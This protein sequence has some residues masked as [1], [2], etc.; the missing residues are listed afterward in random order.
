VRK[1]STRPLSRLRLIGKSKS[2]KSK[3]GNSESNSKRR[4]KEEPPRRPRERQRRELHFVLKSK[5]NSFQKE[6]QK[7]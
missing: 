1:S 4:G 3:R 2:R 6:F 5:K 7:Q